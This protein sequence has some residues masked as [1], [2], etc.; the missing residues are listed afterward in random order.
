[1][2][3]TTTSGPGVATH[4]LG[5]L[6]WLFALLSAKPETCLSLG[7]VEVLRLVF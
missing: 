1:M 6:K 5:A 3:T 4:P 7:P 2:A